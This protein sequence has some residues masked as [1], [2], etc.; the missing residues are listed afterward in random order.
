M[1]IPVAARPQAELAELAASLSTAS[2][3]P[4]HAQ[5]ADGFRRLIRL[6]VWAPGSQ[7][8]AEPELSVAVGVSRGTIRR[9][10]Q[11]LGRGGLVTRIHGKGTFVCADV[12]DLFPTQQLLSIAEAMD[13]HGVA[14]ETT[15]L[16]AT[17][18]LPPKTVADTLDLDE[19]ATCLGLRRI[20][21]V[22]GVPVAY[23]VNFVRT[24]RCPDIELVDFTERRLFDVIENVYGLRIDGGHRT[25]AAQG[26]T[27]EVAGHLGLEVG[28]PVLYLT[29]VT[30]LTGGEPIEYSDV[31]IRGDRMKLSA[32]LRR[33]PAAPTARESRAMMHGPAERS[34]WP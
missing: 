2:A 17:L 28:H 25:F 34:T 6:S 8:L 3:T 32:V 10:V 23:L 21:S 11:T 12:G 27:P 24:E 30:F 13:Q 29:Q 9:A 22:S 4:L 5:V 1:S 14:V 20:R 7:L 16:E 33:H 15:V 19:N 31:W 26:V 18:T